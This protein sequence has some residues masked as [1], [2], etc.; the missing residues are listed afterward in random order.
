MSGDGSPI[1]GVVVTLTNKC[2]KTT[3][4][5]F[6]F[7]LVNRCEN[8][9][10]TSFASKSNGNHFS[11]CTLIS[12]SFSNFSFFFCGLLSL[13]IFFFVHT[14]FHYLLI[15]LSIPSSSHLSTLFLISFIPPFFTAFIFAFFLFP[16]SFSYY[17]LLLVFNPFQSI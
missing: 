1:I 12:I 17:S 6:F 11:I 14:S 9:F 16:A 15:P 7:F 13:D 5:S 4:S 2:K 10:G 3:E 8:C